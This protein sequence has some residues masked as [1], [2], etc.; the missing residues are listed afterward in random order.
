MKRLATMRT[1]SAS[2]VLR[3]APYLALCALLTSSPSLADELV[4]LKNGF[5]LQAD[6]HA[7]AGDNLAV[8]VGGGTIELPAADIQNIS[9]TASTVTPPPPTRLQ[10]ERPVSSTILLARAAAAQGLDPSFLQSV[11]KVESNLRQEATSS[12]GAIGLMQIMP[13]TA[14]GLSIDPR[15]PG[16]NALGGARYLRMLLLRYHFNSALAL[17]AYNAGPGA[18]T[19]FGGVPPYIETRKYIQLVT[20]EYDRLRA[21]TGQNKTQ[22]GQ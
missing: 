14:R 2:L 4:C 1:R 18:V 9:L 7:Q 15:L 17:A 11:A 6:S 3:L 20:R 5:C 12:K 8:R 22:A 19:R 16:D 13:A 10:T 21:T